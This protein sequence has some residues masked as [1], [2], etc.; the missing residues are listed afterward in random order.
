[1][2][3]LF[4][5][6]GAVDVKR[7]DGFTLIELVV[8][9]FLLTVGLIALIS[10]SAMITRLVNNGDSYTEAA[11]GAEGRLELWRG[12]HCGVAATGLE[13]A[14]DG[15]FSLGQGRARGTVQSAAVVVTTT[16]ARGVK[17][18]AFS[19]TGGC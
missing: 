16:L 3:A 14:N 7:M 4:S 2:V 15:L 18:D 11:A 17:V 12:T 5:E 6:T 1:M 13:P 8:A 9:I 10:S 19:V